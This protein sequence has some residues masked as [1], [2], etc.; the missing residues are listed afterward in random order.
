MD[1][2]LFFTSNFFHYLKELWLPLL[3]GFLA[4]GF[5]YQFVPTDQVQKYLGGQG[6]K[7][8]V[9]ASLIGAALPVC[10]I[11][12]LPLALTLRR[13]QASLG[14]VI[15]FLIATPATS[16]PALFICW[17]LLGIGFTVLTFIGA[18]F[19]AIV[20]GVVCDGIKINPKVQNTP[21]QKS[22]CH[23][24]EPQEIGKSFNEKIQKTFK[25]AF[26]TLP[27]GIG[28]EI[29]LGISLSSFILSFQ[30]LQHFIHTY[31]SGLTGYAVIIIFGLVTYVCSTGDV[32]IA[33]AFIKAGM[34]KGQA[35]SYLLVGP[36]T[37]YSTILVV[38][39]EFGRHVLVIYLVAISLISFLFGI[40]TDI[41]LYRFV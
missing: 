36:I 5:F 20:V 41:Y 7:P 9:I 22:C 37:S 27:R 34:S 4:S 15:T 19:M 21:D 12:T 24:E 23:K 1:F 8:I 33:H 25:Y 17:K 35:L 14:A 28:L 26:W 32:P 29:I 18:V 16:I 10:C 38:D 39:K 30:P 3:M 13:K 6:I 11:G 31:L 2:L 40:L